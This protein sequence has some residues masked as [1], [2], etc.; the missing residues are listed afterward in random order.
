MPTLKRFDYKN[1]AAV[2]Q[3]QTYSTTPTAIYQVGYSLKYRIGEHVDTEILYFASKGQQAAA[4]LACM[5]RHK[6][7]IVQSVHYL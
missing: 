2:P 7:C 5:Q 3:K 1:V 6:N 4:T